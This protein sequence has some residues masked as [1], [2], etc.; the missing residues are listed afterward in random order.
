MVEPEYQV[1]ADQ[2]DLCGEGPLWDPETDVLYW[3]DIAGRRVTRHHWRDHRNEV[4]TKEFE[5]AGLALHANGGFVVTNS[6]GAWLWDLVSEPQLL[7]SQAEGKRCRLNDCVADPVGRLFSGSYILDSETDSGFLFRI[8][9]DGTTH[10]V[11]EGM[12]VSNGL[13]FS[14]DE[15]TLYFADSYARVIYSYDYDSLDGGL[16]NR[17]TWVRVPA[18]D[19]LPDGLTVDADGFVWSANW[20]G[21][22]LIRY[23]PDGKVERRIPSPALQTTSL[24]FGGPELTDIF[25]TSACKCDSTELAPPG[26]CRDSFYIGG[27]L[28]HLN[29][30]I[31]GRLEYRSQIDPMEA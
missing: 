15:R 24:A 7:T 23:D 12:L 14:P 10:V 3:T 8:D 29:L 11:D 21:R 2:S 4:I 6:R 1:L 27:R 30:D 20:Y 25:L 28:F 13:G 18:E 19:G 5:V 9:T 16:R 26:Y 31:R 17:R 22:S